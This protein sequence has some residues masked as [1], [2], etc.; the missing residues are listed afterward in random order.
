VADFGYCFDCNEMN[1]AITDRNGVFEFNKISSNHFGH[2]CHVFG[3]PN[4]YCPPIRNVLT[5]LNMGAE[6]GHNE[7][8]LFK[9][10]IGLGELDK[11]NKT[12]ESEIEINQQRLEI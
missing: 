4:D 9:L 5:K 12:I 11:Y 3:K 6:I 8:V 2:N 1:Y 7:I 10:A